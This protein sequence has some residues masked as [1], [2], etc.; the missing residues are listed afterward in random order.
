MKSQGVG[1]GTDLGITLSRGRAGHVDT[2]GGRV[3]DVGAWAVLTASV[4]S[5]TMEHGDQPSEESR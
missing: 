3:V 4:Y 5:V 1:E 2:H